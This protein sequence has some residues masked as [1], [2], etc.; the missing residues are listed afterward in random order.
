MSVFGIAFKAC[1]SA[2][3]VVWLLSLGPS[4][5]C[6]WIASPHPMLNIQELVEEASKRKGASDFSL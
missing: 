1:E 3:A 2:P 5:K 4:I 6:G